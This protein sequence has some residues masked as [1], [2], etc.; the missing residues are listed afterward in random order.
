M[1]SLAMLKGDNHF[2]FFVATGTWLT[3][4]RSSTANDVTIYV[5]RR[6]LAKTFG[7]VLT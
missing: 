7:V 1:N 5:S 4:D 6:P 3:S 2:Q